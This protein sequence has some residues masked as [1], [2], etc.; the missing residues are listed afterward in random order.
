MDAARWVLVSV[1][2]GGLLI[3]GGPAI[4]DAGGSLTVTVRGLPSAA[5]LQALPRLTVVG[6][7]GTDELQTWRIRKNAT[8]KALA[9]GLYAVQARPVRTVKG[10]RLAPAMSIDWFRVKKGK[11]ARAIVKYGPPVSG[12]DPSPVNFELEDACEYTFGDGWTAGY[13]DTQDPMSGYCFDYFG[14]H[15]DHY[16]I[17]L[18]KYCQKRY[19]NSRNYAF[20]TGRSVEDWWC[21][22]F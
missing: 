2:V 16:G 22:R 10:K 20:L 15:G 8:F 13:G 4:G 12:S 3:T 21:R 18:T 5:Q 6:P 9:P 11:S 17:D 7:T 1:A 19:G 14:Y